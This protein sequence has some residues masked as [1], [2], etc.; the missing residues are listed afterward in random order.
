MLNFWGAVIGRA[1]DCDDIKAM[2]RGYVFVLQVMVNC[3]QE[4]ALLLAVYG[5]DRGCIV[6]TATCFNLNEHNSALVHSYYI[7][8]AMART[9][10]SL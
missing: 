6:V 8:V 2:G 10:V 1:D 9:P 5:C 7:N 3:S 4:I